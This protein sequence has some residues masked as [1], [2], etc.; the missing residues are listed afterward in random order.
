MLAKADERPQVRISLKLWSATSEK[1][2]RTHSARNAFLHY[3]RFNLA[4]GIVES[5]RNVSSP[6]TAVDSREAADGRPTRSCRAAALKLGGR[7]AK[8]NGHAKSLWR[9]LD[10]PR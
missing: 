3:G 1:D 7:T 8:R 2:C 4:A 5:L 9:S 10:R 6:D